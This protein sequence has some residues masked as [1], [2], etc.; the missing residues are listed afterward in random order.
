MGNICINTINA[1]GTPLQVDELVGKLSGYFEDNLDI[2][3]VFATEFKATA[4]LSVCSQCTMPQ[5]DLLEITRSLSDTQNLYIRVTAEEPAEEYFDQSVF[6][7]GKWD[8]ENP[9]SINS[10]IHELT[11]QGLEQIRQYIGE[12]GNIDFGEDCNWTALYINNDGYAECPYFQRVE[13]DE[14]KKLSVLLSDG[15]WLYED[16]LTT[17]HVMDILSLLFEE[18]ESAE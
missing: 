5:K 16:D 15:Y 17:V 4:S 1:E 14:N 3:D 10:Q 12:N 13:L 18:H 8:F 7:D 11:L 2:N 9:P 6:T